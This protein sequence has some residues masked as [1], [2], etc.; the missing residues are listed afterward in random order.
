[1]VNSTI[2]MISG[3]PTLL[4]SVRHDLKTLGGVSRIDLVAS[5]QDA[6]ELLSKIQP[7]LIIADWKRRQNGF[8]S[9][10]RL[11]WASSKLARHTPVV[12]V[13][14]RYREDQAVVF[15]QMGVSDYISKSEHLSSLPQILETYLNPSSSSSS[16]EFH[17]IPDSNE[18]SE[19]ETKKTRKVK[20]SSAGTAARVNG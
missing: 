20:T 7:R 11:L 19:P 8:E 18:S 17:P 9:M 3:D 15:Y 5:V 4:E 10:D 12:V 2:L 1:M 13:T 6:C 14:D 16:G